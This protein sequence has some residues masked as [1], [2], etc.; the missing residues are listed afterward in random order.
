M[1]VSGSVDKRR[2]GR[3]GIEV[4]PIGFGAFKIGR[5][6]GIKYR[7]GYDLPDERGVERV[8]CGVL[9]M[10]IN[11]IDTA[12]AY[13]VSEQRLGRALAGRRDEIVLSTKVGETFRDGRSTYDFS[14]SG[15]RGSVEQSLVRLRTDVIDVVFIHSDGDDLRI[16]QETDAVEALTELRRD[17]LVRAIGMSTRTV[18]GA[19]AAMAWS[20]VLMVEYHLQDRSHADVIAEAA[21]ADI[22]IVIKKGLASGHLVP[23]EAIRFVLETEGVGSLV[24][25]SLSLEHLRENVRVAVV[26]ST[27]R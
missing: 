5:N 17:G 16:L 27:E 4:S 6:T 21:R 11:Y 2:L 1:G 15:V 3:T 24:V 10:G 12:P 23:Q 9:D 8:L 7:H 26:R 13:G 22:G 18:Q 14:A 20:D 25:G 19:R